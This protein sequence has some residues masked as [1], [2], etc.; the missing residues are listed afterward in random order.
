LNRLPEVKA[1]IQHD[2][3]KGRIAVEY[4]DGLSPVLEMYDDRNLL[5]TIDIAP[6]SREEIRQECKKWLHAVSW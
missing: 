2:A 4:V 1:F 6:L 5:K 3:D